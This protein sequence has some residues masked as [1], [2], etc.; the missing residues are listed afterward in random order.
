MTHF[1]AAKKIVQ[2]LTQAGFT[3]YFAG[4]WVRDHILGK[5]ADDID[6]ATDATPEQTMKLFNKTVPVGINF[7][8][9]IV[10]QDD[11]HCEVAT[12]RTETGYEDGRRPTKVE[13]ATPKEDAK[14]RDFTINGMFFDPLTDTIY[15]YV[16]GQEDLKK[17][18]VR[19]IGDPHERFKEDRLR[20]IRACR[21]SAR[22]GF[23]I[24]EETAKAIKVH[25]KELFPAVAIERVYDEFRKMCR[26][27]HLFEAALLM[28]DFGL[29]QE[30]FHGFDIYE[31]ENLKTHLSNLSKFPEE[32]YPI[33]FLFE[34][35]DNLT[36]EQKLKMCQKFKVSCKEMKYV[37][38]LQK[39]I[40]SKSLSDNELVELYAHPMCETSMHIG[41]IYE[42]DN[43]FIS[44]HTEKQTKL[45]AH[46]ERKINKTPLIG[47]A[48]LISKGMKAG[49][50]LGQ[51]L[52]KAE[53]IAINEDLSTKEE[54]LARLEFENK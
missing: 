37:E 40:G 44:F 34:M 48:D 12:F 53:S 9:L 32:T 3:A 10:V 4:G 8:I 54:V 17:K 5:D 30:I 11:V 36:L 26:E 31:F 22:F 50:E 46:I 14:R 13:H 1:I 43:T 38:E 27:H 39:W 25:A 15:D 49:K 28:Y 29:L 52:K 41:A 20:M 33:I 7:S 6:I 21:Y 16:G 23:P 2:R 18:I 35:C 42:K 51:M 19:A 24:E 47:S 45:K